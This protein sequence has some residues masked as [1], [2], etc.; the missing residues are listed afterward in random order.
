[1]PG[2]YSIL[3]FLES[4][5]SHAASEAICRRFAHLDQLVLGIRREQPRDHP[6]G[7]EPTNTR[8]SALSSRLG[9]P[10][11]RFPKTLST[12]L[13]PRPCH[14]SQARHLLLHPPDCAKRRTRAPA[15]SSLAQNTPAPAPRAVTAGESSPAQLS[16]TRDPLPVALRHHYGHHSNTF[17]HDGDHVAWLLPS[18]LAASHFYT[19]LS[20]RASPTPPLNNLAPIPSEYSTAPHV[21]CV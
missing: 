17:E 5:G 8:I 13:L 20:R 2:S 16:A 18:D 4:P 14:D 7:N 3:I 19:D 12:I 9:S 10:D 6:K 1:L 15:P 11:D 21:A